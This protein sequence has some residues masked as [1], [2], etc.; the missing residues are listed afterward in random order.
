VRLVPPR[1]IASTDDLTRF[2]C[3]QAAL[4]AW[5]CDHAQR[6]E[7]ERT[8]RTYV[9]I[10]A[11][12]EQLAGFYCLSSYSVERA[13]FG[14]AALARNTPP[15]VPVVLLG[16]LAIHTEYQGHGLG[17]SM[18]HDAVRRATDV[19]DRIGSRALVV[20]AIDDNAAAFYRHH[21]F[22]PFPADPLTLFHRL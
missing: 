20:D 16:R 15:R 4:D 5:L 7:R 8:A 12:G 19:S 17:A 18:L 6:S 9:V 2:T 10:D 14:G 21:G 11:D 3:G 13:T 22:R 1:P